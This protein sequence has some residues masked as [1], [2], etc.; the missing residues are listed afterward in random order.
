MSIKIT[1]KACYNPKTNE[2]WELLSYQGVYLLRGNDN[3]KPINKKEAEELTTLGDIYQ[4]KSY[5]LKGCWT[6][7][8]SEDSFY[9]RKGCGATTNLQEGIALKIDS[10]AMWYK[11]NIVVGIE[12]VIKNKSYKF[13]TA[14]GSYYALTKDE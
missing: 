11:T 10:I 14:S 13:Y 5:N 4:K 3:M 12:E 8:K 9:T 7:Y 1:V 6:L 2:I